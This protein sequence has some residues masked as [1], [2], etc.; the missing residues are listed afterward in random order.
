MFNAMNE[1]DAVPLGYDVANLGL[2]NQKI[3]LLG[4]FAKALHSTKSLV[5]P[6]LCNFDS[7]AARHTKVSL[8]L[9]FSED[10]L[11]TFGRAYGIDVHVDRT[12]E[13]ADGWGC[14]CFGTGKLGK[15][16]IG[17]LEALDGFNGQFFRSL[18]PLIIS[19]DSFKRLLRV[20]FDERRVTTVCQ[21]RIEK[22]WIAQAEVIK[23]KPNEFEDDPAPSFRE[24]FVKMLNTI[25]ADRLGQTVYVVCDENSLPVPKETIRAEVKATF[26]ISIIWKS[27]ILTA[28][29]M[30][31]L[32]VLDQSII[33]F[34][35]AVRSPIFVGLSRSTFSNGVSIESFCRQGVLSESHYIYNLRGLKLGVRHDYG[36]HV[37]PA[38]VT[39]TLYRRR[40]LIPITPDDCSWPV[41]ISAHFSTIGDFTTLS[42]S[43]AGG[44]HVSLVVGTSAADAKTVEGFQIKFKDGSVDGGIEYRARMYDGVW[45]DFGRDGQYVGSRGISGRV[46]G[47]TASLTGRLALSYECICVGV[48][49]GHERV[50]EARWGGECASHDLAPLVAMQLVFRPLTSLVPPSNKSEF[51]KLPA[52]I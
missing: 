52:P 18:V 48:F 32:S 40:A 36:V 7:L 50:V 2:N 42:G 49:A 5:L 8:R 22:D 51:P 33:D 3:A 14:F 24:I 29:E 37:D 34:E 28:D 12:F 47:F 6:S 41:A 46:T 4:L 27:D 20:V 16:M 25:P 26:G 35:I 30:R 31:Q 43:V 39:R 44:R 19:T 38:E 15:D 10:H 23:S 9:A 13:D 17:G 11:F 1:I 45:T 21:L